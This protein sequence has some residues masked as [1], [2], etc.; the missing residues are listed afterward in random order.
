MSS[1]LTCCVRCVPKHACFPE[2]KNNPTERCAKQFCVWRDAVKRNVESIPQPRRMTC[3]PSEGRASQWQ[4]FSNLP[5][6][7]NLQCA[8]LPLKQLLV[9]SK[10]ANALSTVLGCVTNE[11]L[12]LRTLYRRVVQQTL[13]SRFTVAMQE[14][15]IMRET[16][17]ILQHGLQG[18]SARFL[19]L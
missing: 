3:K 15:R 13:D 11:G 10:P 4:L 17:D 14:H 5:L 1:V 7:D 9:D 16:S 12:T 8:D 18:I 2:P 6:H 19:T